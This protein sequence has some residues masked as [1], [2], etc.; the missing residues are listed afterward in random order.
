MVERQPWATCLLTDMLIRHLGAAY[1]EAALRMDYQQLLASTDLVQDIPD[2]HT[3]LS[4]P[5]NWGPYTIISQIWGATSVV[6]LFVS[7]SK[8]KLPFIAHG[9]HY[10]KSTV[11]QIL[12]TRDIV[13]QQGK[14]NTIGL[15]ACPSSCMMF[16]TRGDFSREVPMSYTE[17]VM[18]RSFLVVVFAL[19]TTACTIKATTET[20]TDAVTN[21]SSSTTPGAWVTLSPSA[22]RTVRSA[23]VDWEA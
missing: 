17:D 1:P 6:M 4:D 2:P 14:R 16:W 18:L 19:T 5:H 12:T 10:Q 23:L 20:T 3:F 21:F 11:A 22:V 9:G 8:M 15:I 13:E 7:R